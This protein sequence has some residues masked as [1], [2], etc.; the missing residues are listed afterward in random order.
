VIPGLV[1]LAERL[2]AGW[3]DPLEDE[4]GLAEGEGA[5]LDGIGMVSQLDANGLDGVVEDASRF[6]GISRPTVTNLSIFCVAIGCVPGKV[7]GTEGIQP[8]RRQ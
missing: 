1:D 5:P 3:R 7:S 8:F 2:T 4:L 6:S